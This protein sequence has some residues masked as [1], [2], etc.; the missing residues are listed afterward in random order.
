MLT[1]AE[2]QKLADLSL[3]AVSEEELDRFTGEIDAVLT[4]VSELSSLAAETTGVPAV[5]ELHNVMREDENP[6]EPG[7]YTKALLA[8]APD[9]KDGYV[10]VKKIL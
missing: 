7:L 3:L 5:P 1:K 8:A 2:V 10:R 6:H 4:Y 9:K